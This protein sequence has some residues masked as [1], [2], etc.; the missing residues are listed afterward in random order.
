MKPNF[1]MEIKE[2]FYA[3]VLLRTEHQ[4][5]IRAAIVRKN[6]RKTVSRGHGEEEGRT[7]MMNRQICNTAIE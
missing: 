5:S 4:V 7:K 1:E 3:V 2:P 6:K